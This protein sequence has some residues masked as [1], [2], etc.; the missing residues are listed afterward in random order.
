MY[1]AG[2]LNRDFAPVLHEILDVQLRASQANSHS[3][4]GSERPDD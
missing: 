2:R 4:G 1:T 3:F